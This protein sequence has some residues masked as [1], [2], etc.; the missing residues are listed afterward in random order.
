MDHQLARY[1]KFL[2][3]VLRHR[4]ERIGLTL[5]DGG[6]ADV[7]ELLY[8]ANAAN[9]PLTPELL[10]QVV[11]ENNKQRFAFNQDGTRLRASQGHSIP[12]DL[13]LT[14]VTPPPILY[15]GTATKYMASIQQQGLRPCRRHH[16]HLSG[17]GETAVAVGQRHGTP[18]VLI[19]QAEQMYQAGY[20][21]Y[22]SAN[23]IWLTDHVPSTYIQFP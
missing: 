17:D 2:S 5:D 10:Q 15:H 19:I 7:T 9:V 8:K 4:P 6:W 11:A 21:F 14:P 12:V 20:A 22:R 13:G 23:G 16:V 18:M 1:S 3:L